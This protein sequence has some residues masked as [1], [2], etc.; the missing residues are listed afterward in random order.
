MV[1]RNDVS[2]LTNLFSLKE[3]AGCGTV[4]AGFRNFSQARQYCC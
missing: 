4:M 1:P 3:L 2:L